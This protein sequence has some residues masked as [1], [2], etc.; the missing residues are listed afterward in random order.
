MENLARRAYDGEVNKKVKEELQ[1]AKIPVFELPAYMNGEVKTSY[2]GILH[3]FIFYR[4]WSYWIC[5]GDMPLDVANY[6]YENYKDL[7]I[8]AGGD[9]GNVEPETVSINPLYHKELH[10]LRERVGLKE[11]ME[12]SKDIVDDKSQPRFVDSY[13]IDTQLGLCK[14]AEVIREKDIH[15][16]SIFE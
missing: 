1:I 14:L 3:G 6:I 12:L 8:R 10:R 16:K 11:Y 2:I 13:H 4:A 7:K 15:M 9:C 5:D